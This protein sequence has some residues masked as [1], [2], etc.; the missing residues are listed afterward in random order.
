MGMPHKVFI[1]VQGDRL[2]VVPSARGRKIQHHNEAWYVKVPAY[3]SLRNKDIHYGFDRVTQ[4]DE[5]TVYWFKNR[6]A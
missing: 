3:S 1:Q 4:G 6:E 5:G 2:M